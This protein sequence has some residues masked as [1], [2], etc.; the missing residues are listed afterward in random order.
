MQKAIILFYLA[1]ANILEV[2]ACKM[3]S[4]KSK[5]TNDG[6]SNST[7]TSNATSTKK[8][9]GKDKSK[10]STSTSTDE[11]TPAS[12]DYRSILLNQCPE[13]QINYPLSYLN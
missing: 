3:S 5:G 8:S 13:N 12:V 1:M 9:K 10:E 11:V 4:K 6:S 2:H 7:S